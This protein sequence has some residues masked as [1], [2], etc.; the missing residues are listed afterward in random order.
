MNT[1][2]RESDTIP[3][4]NSS[5]SG[6]RRRLSKTLVVS[7]TVAVVAIVGLVVYFTTGPGALAV[8][9]R[10]VAKKSPPVSDDEV[11]EFASIM[12]SHGHQDL[13]EFQ[14]LFTDDVVFR[15]PLAP[16]F[17]GQDGIKQIFDMFSSFQLRSWVK[18][19]AVDTFG[20]STMAFVE[21]YLA[22]TNAAGD[23]M[24]YRDENVVAILTFD[25]SDKDGPLVVKDVSVFST[26]FSQIPDK[27][28]NEL[29]ANLTTTMDGQCKDMPKAAAAHNVG[30]VYIQGQHI[31]NPSLDDI[32][33]ICLQNLEAMGG[34]FF[35]ELEYLH[36]HSFQDTGHP[37]KNQG[38]AA[39]VC[40]QSFHGTPV[41][42]RHLVALNFRQDLSLED[43]IVFVDIC[44]N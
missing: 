28:T 31:T 36:S 14:K 7:G 11:F 1:F 12:V 20:D 30:N 35:C 42:V 26:L 16:A 3:L 43:W 25:R 37:N 6:S 24:Q 4:T 9:S 29:L 22:I 15:L 5:D 23:Q 13:K 38:I 17:H 33:S 2:E 34:K 18:N 39:A 40:P 21:Y 27:G 8:G 44:H 19:V 32:S 41:H 10:L